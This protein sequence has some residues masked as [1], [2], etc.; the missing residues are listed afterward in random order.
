MKHPISNAPSSSLK[1]LEEVDIF[2]YYPMLYINQHYAFFTVA[3]SFCNFWVSGQ[4]YTVISWIRGEQSNYC[5]EVVEK[6]LE[7]VAGG[8]RPRATQFPRSY[9]LPRD[10]GLIDCTPSS[11]EITVLLSNIV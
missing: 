11:L 10:N 7:T 4:Q 2:I 9:P 8:R 1:D 3:R 5:P 6:I